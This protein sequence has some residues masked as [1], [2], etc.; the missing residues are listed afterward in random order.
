MHVLSSGQ[1]RMTANIPLFYLYYALN[2]S[3]LDREASLR[4]CRMD[5]HPACDFF[6]GRLSAAPPEPSQWR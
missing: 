1:R 5:S 2:W 4:G 3:V 6:M